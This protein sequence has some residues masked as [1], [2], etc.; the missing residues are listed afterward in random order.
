MAEQ[1]ATNIVWHQGAVTRADR[2]KLNGHRGCTVWLTGLS[3]SGKSTIAV[4]LEKA[5]LSRGVRAY[6]L[7]G[8]NVR[9]GLN[10]N[11]GFSPADRTENI[12][13]IGEVAKL[14]TDA[15]LVALTAFISPY[16]ADRDQ[17]RALMPDDFVEV[18]VDCPLE[19]C[20]QR[21]VKGLYEKARAGKIPEFT[22]ISAP[23]E[24]PLNPEITLRT[25]SSTVEESVAQIV[26]YLTQRGTVPA[27]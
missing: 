14:F 12:R 16:R 23:Y 21:D 9:H 11:L 6:I 5:L 4:E 7:D 22:G 2:E 25:A 26:K 27:A 3:G 13:R 24:P 15:G 20:E 1:K 17:V 18:L 10:K 19:V 8:D